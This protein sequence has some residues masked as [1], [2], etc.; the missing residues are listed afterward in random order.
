[1]SLQT[2]KQ[3]KRQPLVTPKYAFEKRIFKVLVIVGVFSVGLYIYSLS[4]VIY[5]VVTRRTLERE[6]TQLHS[7]IGTKEAMYLLA[8]NE[9]NYEM[10]RTA[11]FVEPT[12]II[13]ESQE[14]VAFNSR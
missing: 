11:G 10:A 12:T 2:L 6:I 1:M 4:S 5:G 7:D 13:Y 8:T 3:K 14:R 9:L